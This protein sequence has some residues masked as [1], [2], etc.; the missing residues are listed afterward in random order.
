MTNRHDQCTLGVSR[1][2]EVA[3]AFY[4]LDASPYSC[5]R[6]R[7]LWSNIMLRTS[8][9]SVLGLIL[10]A[11][12]SRGDEKQLADAARQTAELSGYSFTIEEGNAGEKGTRQQVAGKYQKGQPIFFLAD[13]IEFYKKG[14]VLVYKDGDNWQKSRTGT[15][16]DPLR[17]LGDRKSV[18]EG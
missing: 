4:S 17:I 11:G 8:L 16:S 13:K 2:R 1:S 9:T 10:L 18:G 5:Y 6:E 14:E 7:N 3:V 15:L 12:T